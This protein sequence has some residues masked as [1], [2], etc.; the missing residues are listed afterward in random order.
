MHCR[1]K[2]TILVCTAHHQFQ[3]PARLFLQS[4]GLSE[5]S[6][7]ATFFQP[8]HTV[9]CHVMLILPSVPVLVRTLQRNGTNSIYIQERGRK[10]FYHKALAHVI[11]EVEK[12]QNLQSASWRPRRAM[13][14]YSSSATTKAYKGKLTV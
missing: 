10:E 2:H 11:M 12:S 9:K 3:P 5:A 7:L 1:H 8:P 4:P 13:V 14:L 6:L